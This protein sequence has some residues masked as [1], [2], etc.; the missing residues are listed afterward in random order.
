MWLCGRVLLARFKEPNING[1]D[2]E[3]ESHRR[4]EIF[5]STEGSVVV[6]AHTT[7]KQA[8]ERLLDIKTTTKTVLQRC[9]A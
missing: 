4:R 3:R 5:L 6:S 7:N 9:S 2:Y 1:K 8:T